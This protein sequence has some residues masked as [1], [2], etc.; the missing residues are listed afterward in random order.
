M[1]YRAT[2]L[3]Y[4]AVAILI[5]SLGVRDL[6]VPWQSDFDHWTGIFEVACAAIISISLL[7]IWWRGNPHAFERS[8]QIARADRRAIWSDKKR[9]VRESSMY[10][11][12]ALGLIA[13]FKH[14]QSQ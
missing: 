1:G 4:F 14:L 3:A 8:E 13:L 2:L 5:G 7:V 6:S 10:V 12:I 9:L 11:I